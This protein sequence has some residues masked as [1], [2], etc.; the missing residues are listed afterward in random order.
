MITEQVL[1]AFIAAL[2]TLI[3]LVLRVQAGHIDHM[4]KQIDLLIDLCIDPADK[5]PH[6]RA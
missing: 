2:V 6:D 4:Q 3:G 5:D 1:L